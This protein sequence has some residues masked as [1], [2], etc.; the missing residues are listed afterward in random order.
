MFTSRKEAAKG[1]KVPLMLYDPKE[2]FRIL[3]E[4]DMPAI[5]NPFGTSQSAMARYELDD[6]TPTP[7][8]LLKYA[9]RFD[10]SM[11]YLYGR[12]DNPHGEWYEN[13]PD[14]AQSNPELA[15]FVEMCFEPGSVMNE[16]L[17]DTLVRMLSEV[18]R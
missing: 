17:K 16:R 10:V 8:L 7:E 13:K 9:D 4:I 2:Y 14:L 1:E 15:R 5:I 11:D 12:T 18:K 3:M 6:A